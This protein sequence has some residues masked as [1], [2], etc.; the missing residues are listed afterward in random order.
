[1]SQAPRYAVI[2]PYHKEDRGMLERCINSVKHQ[3]LA[4][5]HFLMADGFPQDWID[6]ERVRHIKL[7]RAHDDN[8]NTPRGIGALLAAAERYDGIALLDADNWLEPDHVDT[9]A[10]AARA[11]AGRVCDY[12]IARR[13][14][15]RPDETIMKV[16]EEPI[17]LHVDTSCFF[18]L[19]GSYHTLGVWALMPRKAAPACDRMFYQALRRHPLVAAV[20]H[21]AT[22][23]FHCR[24]ASAYR[25]L[26][27]APPP[28]AKPNVN[29]HAFRL[30]LN[31]LSDHEIELE[32]RL[33][34]GPL[35]RPAKP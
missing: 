13:N 24:Y 30:W 9:C 10:A 2:T 1:M 28:G 19:R 27:E 7:D 20:T 12:V 29:S 18:F 22:V 35:A 21:K 14:F 15:R 34:G 23:N 11:V 5:D 4:A 17:Q 25:A 6:G 32:G 33:A 26:G 16:E 31:S 3:T 8:G